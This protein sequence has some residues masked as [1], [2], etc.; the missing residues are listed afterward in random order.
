MIRLLRNIHLQQV[1]L[2]IIVNLIL[3]LVLSIFTIVLF[4]IFIFFTFHWKKKQLG[5]SKNMNDKND[6]KS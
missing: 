1:E 5:Q 4:T 6:K 3:N 2:Y